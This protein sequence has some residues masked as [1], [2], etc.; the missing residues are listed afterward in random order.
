MLNKVF[1]LHYETNAASV[2]SCLAA[3]WVWRLMYLIFYTMAFSLLRHTLV[4]EKNFIVPCTASVSFAGV[5]SAA[6][7]SSA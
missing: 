5:S 7:A 3:T 2:I 4:Y 6:G 1:F